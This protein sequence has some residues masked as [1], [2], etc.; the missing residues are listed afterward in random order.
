MAEG[1][2]RRRSPLAV[3]RDVPRRLRAAALEQVDDARRELMERTR[4]ARVGLVLLGIAAGLALVTLTT[5]AV[6]LTI[7]LAEVLPWWGAILAIVAPLAVA[8]GI[9]A[10]VGMRRISP[11]SADDLVEEETRTVR[12][13]TA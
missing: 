6:A 1:S 12:D 9:L 3:V 7:A 2:T 5:L 11:P 4:E 13:A 10:A 8:A